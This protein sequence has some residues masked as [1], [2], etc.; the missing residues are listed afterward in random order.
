[1]TKKVMFII[2]GFSLANNLCAQGFFNLDFESANIS[3]FSPGNNN[4]PTNA[5]IPGWT[6]YYFQPGQGVEP[7]SEAAYDALSIG[8][9]AIS[10]NDTNT[11]ASFV[12]L[13]GQFSVFLFGGAFQQSATIGQRGLVPNGTQSL[14]M[15]IGTDG[16]VQPIGPFTVTLDGQAI[17]MVALSTLPNLTI[18]FLEGTYLHLR[19]RLPLWKSQPCQEGPMLSYWIRSCFPPN[20]FPSPGHLGCLL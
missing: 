13:Q 5:A 6:A 11:S 19:I 16:Y 14:R 18:P 8:G 12:P 17:S 4:V 9:A 2:F 15:E 3:G 20:Q 7:V 1:M 10:V